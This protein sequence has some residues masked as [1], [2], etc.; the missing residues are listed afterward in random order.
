[1]EIACS[2]NHLCVTFI[3]LALAS[4]WHDTWNQMHGAR[5]FVTP[6]PS[7]SK[8]NLWKQIC[9]HNHEGSGGS[10]GFTVHVASVLWFFSFTSTKCV[11]SLCANL[12][13]YK[14][15][16]TEIKKRRLLAC[17]AVERFHIVREVMQVILQWDKEQDRLMCSIYKS[18]YST[19]FT[20]QHQHCSASDRF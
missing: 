10:S 4:Q 12:V 15:A 2:K 17:R 16:S 18:Y 1:M 19:I 8:P 9:S 20:L 3:V 14:W 7:V 11:Y 13:I 6:S 5:S